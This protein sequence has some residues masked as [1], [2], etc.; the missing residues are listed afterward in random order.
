MKNI[1]LIKKL[2][3]LGLFICLSC[4]RSSWD[5]DAILNTNGQSSCCLIYKNPKDEIELEFLK[6]DESVS[7]YINLLFSKAASKNPLLITIKTSDEKNQT[8]AFIREGS[9][10]ICL[11]EESKNFIISSLE[12][13][14][15]VTLEFDGIKEE[16]D[17]SFFQKNYKKFLRSNSLYNKVIRTLF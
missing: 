1:S 14:L 15:S 17:P 7:C 11:N 3:F 9:Q 12:K 4:Q 2:I 13:G 5:C 8:T 6:I 16:I 10:K